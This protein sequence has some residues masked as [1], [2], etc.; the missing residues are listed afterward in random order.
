MEVS[1]RTNVQAN[2]VTQGSVRGLHRTLSG[3]ALYNVD[4]QNVSLER[5]CL[6]RN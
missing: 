5:G 2:E 4:E 3:L 1:T 6:H